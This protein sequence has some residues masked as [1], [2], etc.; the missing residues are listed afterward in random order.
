MQSIET[1][2]KFEC[3][4]SRL[5]RQLFK[6]HA[7]IL[8]IYIEP[9]WNKELLAV[10]GNV[11]LQRQD[12]RNTARRLKLVAPDRIGSADRERVDHRIDVFEKLPPKIR[13]KSAS[14]CLRVRQHTVPISTRVTA[15]FSTVTSLS[16]A[17]HCRDD[18]ARIVY[19][20]ARK[21]TIHAILSCPLPPPHAFPTRSSLFLFEIV[22]KLA[23]AFF[24]FIIFRAITLSE[25]PR[26]DS[27]FHTVD[28][29]LANDRF[30]SWEHE[31]VE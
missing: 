1:Y 31:N 30:H 17:F 5:K 9:S 26:V 2:W 23:R 15:L 14:M 4:T 3:C 12:D 16:S 6:R 10:Q 18:S 24:V 11:S 21:T 29:A 22:P 20:A 28:F 19:R 27:R 8:T 7:P 13:G 25:N